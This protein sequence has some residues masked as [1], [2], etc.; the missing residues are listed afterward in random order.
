MWIVSWI[1]YFIRKSFY[2]NFNSS[3]EFSTTCKY[4]L[5]SRKIWQRKWRLSVNRAGRPPFQLIA[6]NFVN[7][8]SAHNTCE[9]LKYRRTGEQ[10]K[11]KRISGR[12]RYKPIIAHYQW[13]FFLRSFLS[14]SRGWAWGCNKLIKQV[15]MRNVRA[16]KELTLSKC[17][18]SC[19]LIYRV[20][21]SQLCRD[22]ICS[23]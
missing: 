15:T 8:P 18:G 20:R 9:Y 5:R 6:G 12:E 22:I 13:L 23:W 14:R 4:Q 10:G 7:K 2:S 11:D 21:G 3:V 1:K 16:K 17:K 19:V